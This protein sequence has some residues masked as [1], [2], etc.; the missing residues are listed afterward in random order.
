M[1][2]IKRYLFAFLFIFSCFICI[3][4]QAF[5]YKAFE[6][7]PSFN[8]NYETHLTKQ[9][10][11]I[12]DELHKKH[13]SI[14]FD[15]NR[16]IDLTQQL[17]WLP[18]KSIVYNKTVKFINFNTPLDQLLRL[19]K[20]INSDKLSFYIMAK[21][22]EAGQIN[23]KDPKRL[24][25]FKKLWESINF[26]YED[27]VHFFN[28]FSKNLE[29]INQKN[30]IER[31]LFH[32]NLTRAA[33]LVKHYKGASAPLQ[34]FR[35]KIAEDPQNFDKMILKSQNKYKN[36]EIVNYFYIRHLLKKNKNDKAFER[37]LGIKPSM[38]PDK[39][40]RI[41]YSAAREALLKKKYKLA[42][43]IVSQ[44]DMTESVDYEEQQWFRGWIKFRFLD[45][46]KGAIRDFED[47]YDSALYSMS[48]SRA[49][50][51]LQRVYKELGDEELFGE[52]NEKAKKY[53]SRFYGQ[54]FYNPK[55]LK[56]RKLASGGKKIESED[57]KFL[58]GLK[59]Y[60]NRG[61]YHR[62]YNFLSEVREHLGHKYS[63]DTIANYYLKNEILF[64][65]VI[66]NK[67]YTN[68]GGQMKDYGYP[69]LEF[70]SSDR[71][72]IIYHALIRQ[73]SEFHY[74]AKSSAGAYGLMQL[75]PATAGHIA[76]KIRMD[77]LSY[78]L[79]PRSNL[80][81]GVYYFDEM[82]DRYNSLVLS[83][84]AYNAGP[85]NVN[86]WIKRYGDF[87]I[88]KTIEEK[89]DWIEQIPFRET[90]MYVKKVLEN[91]F[92]YGHIIG[93]EVESMTDL[94]Y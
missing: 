42:L 56:I 39:W 67:Y 84:C 44:L 59:Y 11:K 77:S 75:M 52:W 35:M 78:K 37:L 60:L 71:F 15:L 40:W 43:D 79:Y 63:I 24:E 5:A 69:V 36:D 50:Y 51:W 7:A 73:E 55:D 46:A 29:F 87:R 85:G 32:S 83:I 31:N 17:E 70:N 9:D 64:P 92:I 90:R 61:E 49:I 26:K 80:K 57:M 94:I 62:S 88:F 93:Y 86:K 21:K 2:R 58:D 22:L 19:R 65:G 28:K 25:K 16:I 14:R 20:Y 53:S 54:M 82:M 6:I 33:Y 12:L 34:R 4:E 47:A 66:L 68:R 23:L 41:Y 81:S 10:K 48:K 3:A 74:I 30:K 38:Y 76:K 8:F 1:L 18:D 13:S 45:D 89:I 27:E 72:K 91:A